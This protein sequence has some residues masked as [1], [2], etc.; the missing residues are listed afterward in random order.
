[1][2]YSDFS[3]NQIK[4]QFSLDIVEDRVL[5]QNPRAFPVSDLLK[6]LMERYIPLANWINTEKAR[7][8]FI[9]APILA[10][11]KWQMKDRMSLFSGV[12]F[13]VDSSQG[14]NGRCDYIISKAK[15]QLMVSAP[16]VMLVEAKNENIIN[17][18]PQCIAEMIAA[19]RFNQA[20]HNTVS[21]LYGVVTTGSLWRFLKLEDTPQAFVDIKEY[22]IE[23]L[24]QIMGILEE[25]V[26]S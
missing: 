5:F 3:L 2:S 21:T 12:D 26:D 18:I 9:I 13:T 20:R 22:Y 19:Q 17:G 16:V 8:E 25:I 7:S 10:E 14:L 11:L 24:S 4:E 23:N 1:M 15:E 6:Q